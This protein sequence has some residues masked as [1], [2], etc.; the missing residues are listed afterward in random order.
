M[1]QPYISRQGLLAIVIRIQNLVKIYDR[2]NKFTR[3]WKSGL[4][5]RKRLGLTRTFESSKD[6][7]VL[8]WQ[9]P[10]LG[11]L[12]FFVYFYL[13]SGL[14]LFLLSLFVYTILL[15]IWQPIGSWIGKSEGKRK[16]LADK[17]F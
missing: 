10:L 9:M 16:K 2:D 8:I 4:A 1:L 14:W 3:E 6:L 5:I 11:F 7:I 15:G 12:I 17:H 13:D